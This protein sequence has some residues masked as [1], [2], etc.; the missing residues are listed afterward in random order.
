VERRNGPAL[1]TSLH[2]HNRA[3]YNADARSRQNYPENHF[4]FLIQSPSGIGDTRESSCHLERHKYYSM[5]LFRAEGPLG[6]NYLVHR[7][8][9]DNSSV[10]LGFLSEV[11]P[12]HTLKPCLF[13]HSSAEYCSHPPVPGHV[14]LVISQQISQH[15]GPTSSAPSTNELCR[16]SKATRYARLAGLAHCCVL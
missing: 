4:R 1:Y 12:G 5:G 14:N 15:S 7:T 10:R 3:T 2:G 13:E 6:N 11:G 8:A 9:K 16:V